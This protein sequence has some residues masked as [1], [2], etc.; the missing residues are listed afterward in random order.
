MAFITTAEL[1]NYP[2]PITEAQWNKIDGVGGEQVDKVLAYASQNIKDYLD[3]DIELTAYTERM[4][5]SGATTKLMLNQYPIAS[6]TGISSTDLWGNVITYSTGS[7]VVNADAGIVEWIDKVRNGFLPPYVYT[8]S[9]TAGYATIPG[10]IKH[11]TALQA[12]SMLQPLFRG[13]TNFVQV[14]LVEGMEESIVDLLESYRRKR[15]G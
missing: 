10:P 14:D 15:I 2:L 11:A 12:L 6:L 7:F 13:G 8:V 5:V 9:Y 4:Y 1:K 3:R